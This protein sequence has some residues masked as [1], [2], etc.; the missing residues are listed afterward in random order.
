MKKTILI[1]LTL[2][3]ILS[4]F[5]CTT[6]PETTPTSEETIEPEYTDELPFNFALIIIDKIMYKVYPEEAAVV[7][8][9]VD[10]LCKHSN[11]SCPM[12]RIADSFVKDG[13]YY[14]VRCSDDRMMYGTKIC[15]YDLISGEYKVLYKT[16]NYDDSITFLQEADNYLF[17]T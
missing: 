17:F 12:T 11:D 15:T 5:S 14:Y 1:F 9:C 7:P 3:L 16:E 8:A 4:L 10:P 6:P 13:L 2:S